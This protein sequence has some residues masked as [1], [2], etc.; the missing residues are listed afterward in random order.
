MESLLPGG[1][2]L[3]DEVHDPVAHHEQIG[4]A[5]DVRMVHRTEVCNEAVALL[6]ALAFEIADVRCGVDRDRARHDVMIASP[7]EV[8]PLVLVRIDRDDHVE[9][10]TSAA[11]THTVVGVCHQ[12]ER[13]HRDDHECPHASRLAARAP[14]TSADTLRR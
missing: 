7:E 13:D 12:R 2:L 5:P 10:R 3:A 8:Q 1:R 6:E 9:L 14:V 4:D 11:A